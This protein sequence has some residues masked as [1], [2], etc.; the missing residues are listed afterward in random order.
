MILSDYGA[1]DL[2][3]AFLRDA[4]ETNAEGAY[5]RQIPLLLSS[6]NIG[7]EFAYKKDLTFAKLREAVQKGAAAVGVRDIESVGAHAVVIEKIEADFVCIRDPLPLGSGAAYKL[8]V[9][10]FLKYWHLPG[11]DFGLAIIIE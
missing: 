9:E 5:L 4:L 6:R 11:K 8:S 1:N 10:I 2:P 3:E 7:V